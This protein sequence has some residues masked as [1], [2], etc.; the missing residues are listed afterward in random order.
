MDTI[1][2]F[3][4]AIQSGDSAKVSTFL[5]ADPSLASARKAS[6]VSAILISIY[7]GQPE[8]TKL[9]LNSGVALNVFEAAA[10]G[11]LER[12]VTLLDKEPAQLDAFSADGFTPLGLA[13][14]FGHIEI[15]KALLD[16]KAPVN[17]PSNNAQRVMPL[18]S[19]VAGR[20]FEI[21]EALLAQGAEV[22]A[23]QQDGFTPLFGA[24]QN[25][26]LEM[27]ELLLRHGADIKATNREG[28]TALTYAQQSGNQAVINLLRQNGATE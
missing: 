6:G 5:Q 19:A 21:A 12:L 1:Q 27:V 11:Q 17:L 3:F 15:V 25:G 22:N 24:A 8:I 26:Q 9:L 2:E 7:Y 20:H 23:V 13:S 16:R 14:F 10:A 28:Q 18:H 4:E